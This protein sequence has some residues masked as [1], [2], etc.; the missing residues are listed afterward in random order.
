MSGDHDLI[1]LLKRMRYDLTDMQVKV[2]AA[3]N[4]AAGLNLPPSEAYTC[5]DGLCR[6]TFRSRYKLAEHVHTSHGGPIPEHWLAIEAMAEEPA[7][8]DP[9]EAAA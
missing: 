6:L 5:P 2:T 3:L 7:E 1:E 4:M 8:D 9:D